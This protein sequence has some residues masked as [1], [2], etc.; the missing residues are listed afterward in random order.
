MWILTHTGNAVN[1]DQLQSI[2]IDGQDSMKVV[3]VFSADRSVMLGKYQNSDHAKQ[4]IRHICGVI[5][6]DTKQFMAM[7][8]K[9]PLDGN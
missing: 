8:T 4:V 2:D 7:P 6:S 1:T 3:G 9:W 5:R